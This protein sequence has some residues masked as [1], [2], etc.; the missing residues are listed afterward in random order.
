[1]A[2]RQTMKRLK[3]TRTKGK[4]VTYKTLHRKLRIYNAHLTEDTLYIV[5]YL[6]IYVEDFI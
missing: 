3:N 1:M 2:E 5:C 4:T 6:A